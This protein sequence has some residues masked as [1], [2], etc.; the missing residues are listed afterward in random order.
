MKSLVNVSS[1]GGCCEVS[2]IGASEGI[3]VLVEPPAVRAHAS[4]DLRDVVSKLTASVGTILGN[5]G[6]VEA[7]CL[8][9][10]HLTKVGLV[11]QVETLS[12]MP[13]LNVL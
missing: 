10:S 13:G 8:E 6:C 5:L 7:L 4:R 3:P 11:N 1:E 12:G 9:S 2:N